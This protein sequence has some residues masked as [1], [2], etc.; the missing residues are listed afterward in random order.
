[1][2]EVGDIVVF[3]LK[4]ARGRKS[5]QTARGL[6]YRVAAS[7]DEAEMLGVSENTLGVFAKSQGRATAGKMLG[8]D[9][10]PPE[11]LS[12]V[13]VSAEDVLECLPSAVAE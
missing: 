3:S 8:D 12:A 5:K 10:L 4:G 6:V 1:M 11:G 7:A 9:H 2:P 13:D